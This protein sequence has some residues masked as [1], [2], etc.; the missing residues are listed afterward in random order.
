[1]ALQYAEDLVAG[2]EAHLGNSA[3]VTE[4]DTDLGWGEALAGVFNDQLDDLVGGGLEP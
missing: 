3:L 1:L 2:D 4:D